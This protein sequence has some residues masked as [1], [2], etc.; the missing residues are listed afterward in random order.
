VAWSEHSP[1]DQM[2]MQWLG[3]D[4]RAMSIEEYVYW[5]GLMQGESLR[6]YCENFRRRMF[7]TS[8]AIFWSYNDCWPV[9]RSWAIVDY[10]LRRMPAFWNVRRAMA[11]IH[12]V[13]ATE[14]EQVT[15]FGINETAAPVKADLR[16]GVFRLG[17]GYAVD[18]S[19]AVTLAPNA[20][21]PLASFPL[22][23]WREAN[24]SM[25]FAVLRRDGRVLARN[26][27][28]L[29]LLKEM[30]WPAPRVTVRLEGGR[31]IFES[32]AFAWGVCLDLDGERP[33][34]DNFFDIYPDQPHEIPWPGKT[35]PKILRVGN[36]V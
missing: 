11:P 18:R 36:L 5:G 4:I 14:G 29:P 28:F 34:A 6:E 25:A 12:L 3:K 30:A 33:L 13:I 2:I 26:R 35:P 16:Y 15:V 1:I 23:E 20:S 9:T 27:L 21:S 10:Y 8:S 31:A 17:G 32:A 19:A 24:A 7:D 22:A